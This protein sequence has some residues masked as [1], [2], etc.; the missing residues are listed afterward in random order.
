[1][2][3][4]KARNS[5]IGTKGK[6]KEKI[7]RVILKNIIFYFWKEREREREREVSSVKTAI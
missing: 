3:E 1:M 6:K 2:I 5:F 4:S 7:A